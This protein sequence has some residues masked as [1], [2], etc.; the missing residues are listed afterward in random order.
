MKVASNIQSKNII[1]VYDL[2]IIYFNGIGLKSIQNQFRAHK[3]VYLF[4]LYVK[5]FIFHSLAS[6]DIYETLTS[7]VYCTRLRRE[8][9][10]KKQ[11]HDGFRNAIKNNV[12]I[13]FYSI[14][15]EIR[16]NG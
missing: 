15:Q 2:S 4:I 5:R 3:M 1:H 8:R 10:E 12:T 6:F 7:L 9:L 11:H 14:L 16:L 13:N